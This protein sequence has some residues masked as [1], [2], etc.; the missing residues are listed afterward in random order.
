M[1]CPQREGVPAGRVAH[2]PEVLTDPR[3]RSRDFFE[4]LA[5]VGAG[6]YEYPGSM[7]RIDGHR[8]TLRLPPPRL[9][10]HNEYIYKELLGVTEEEYRRLETQGIAA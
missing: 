2:E 5:H 9:G 4:P 3:L 1:L 6:T 10:E 8:Q 7:W